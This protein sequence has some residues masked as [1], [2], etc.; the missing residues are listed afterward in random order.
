[1]MPE[2]AIIK[3]SYELF[4]SYIR[5][6]L[7]QPEKSKTI[8]LWKIKMK[9][10]YLLITTL[11]LI[12]ALSTNPYAQV[13][14]N[15]HTI[16]TNAVGAWSVYAVDVDG[17]DDI[18]ILS[19]SKDDDKI[20]WYEN[21]GNQNFTA[22]TITINADGAFSVFAID[23]DG[24]SDMD[25]LSAAS[26]ESSNFIGDVAW[27]ENDSNQNFT[28]HIIAGNLYRPLTVYA[29]DMDGDS[30]ID[31]LSAIWGD[32]QVIWYEN[33]GNQN[34]TA[35]II[36]VGNWTTYA[37]AADVDG[38]LDMD[39]LSSSA[40]DDFNVYQVTWYENDGSQNFTPHI[41]STDALGAN[42]VYAA[43]L[44]SDFD[45]DILSASYFDNR[46]AWY[47]NDGNQNFTTHTITSNTLNAWAVY[48]EDIDGDMDMDVLSASA[49]DNKIVWYE[50][51]GSQN[52]TAHNIATNTLH[53]TAVY[54]TDIDGDSDVDVLAP[55]RYSNSIYWYE[56]LII[57]GINNDED[58]SPLPYQFILSQNYPNPFNP[59]TKISYHLS[60]Q[61][62]VSL[63]VY[64]VL[65][66][67]IISLVNEEKQA[68]V[69]ELNFDGS[70]LASGIYYC[71][72]ITNT[73]SSSIKM[74][75]LK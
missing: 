63:K 44:D 12:L 3:S 21:D 22:H 30:D 13:N 35:H 16:T 47:E 54:A 50:N 39:I 56:N 67:E 36:P 61:G 1:M 45:L 66:S 41:I 29:L 14:F 68:G 70:Q 34:F 74:L 49:G 42:C 27:Y 18:D 9:M 7:T 59:T 62:F 17:D 31:V 25:V 58:I 57:T 2:V 15:A 46:I 69:Y 37:Y 71:R 73:H 20:A 48:V 8:I 65:G 33:D 23:L 38:D 43:D 6:Q 28:A 52:F 5:F 26:G 40:D 4:Y 55:S 53:A 75:L 32:K 64:N 60:E 72:L 10:I 24:D 51:N 19:A 11:G